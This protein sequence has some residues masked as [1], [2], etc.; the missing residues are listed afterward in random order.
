LGKELK[1]KDII[2]YRK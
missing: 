2:H 1:H